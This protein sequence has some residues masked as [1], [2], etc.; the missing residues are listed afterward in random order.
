LMGSARIFSTRRSGS[1]A[2]SAELSPEE[3]VR[4]AILCT[5]L[6]PRRP[7]SRASL[8]P[9]PDLASTFEGVETR[10]LRLSGQ[11]R[12]FRCRLCGGRHSWCP[13][14]PPRCSEL[15]EWAS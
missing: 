4:A 7:I 1:V 9:F 3:H 2:A 14:L 12:L 15:A 13:A 5:R 11:G 10:R 6:G 8:H